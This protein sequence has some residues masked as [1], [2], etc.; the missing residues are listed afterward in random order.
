[1]YTR[2][3][4]KQIANT[5]VAQMGG[6]GKLKAMVGAHHFC[7]L[8]KPAGVKFHF[9]GSRKANIC[10]VEYDVW[11]DLYN[12]TLHKFSPKK[13]TCKEVYR[14]N[15]AYCDMLKD[16]FESETGLYLSF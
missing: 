10:Q 13:A 8:D 7:A 5:I 16:L 12:F 1:M 15:G 9:K 14:C 6:S 2:E 3:K 4:K 11:S